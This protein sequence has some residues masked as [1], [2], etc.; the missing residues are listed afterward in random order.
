[1]AQEVA[2]V[3]AAVARRE[4]E[5]ELSEMNLKRPT[6]SFVRLLVPALTRKNLFA[7]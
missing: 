3:I 7:D 6:N 5:I 2:E 1:V 4:V